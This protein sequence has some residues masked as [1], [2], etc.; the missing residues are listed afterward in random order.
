MSL[1]K[2]FLTLQRI[3][4]HS[5]SGLSNPRTMLG[6]DAVSLHMYFI[7]FKR[8]IGFIYGLHEL[9]DEETAVLPNVS[10]YTLYA[11]ED[12]I[13]LFLTHFY[14]KVQQNRICRSTV[15]I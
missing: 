2:Q 8:T 5:S 15:T 12:F 10:N 6:H 9:G 4:V 14:Y 3:T 11:S 7:T 1:G 13:F